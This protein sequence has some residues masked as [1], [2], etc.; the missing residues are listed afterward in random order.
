MTEHTL[1]AACNHNLA[2]NY[3]ARGLL[4]KAETFARRAL[5]VRQ[6]L[7][8]SDH[9]DIAESLRTCAAILR[10]TGRDMEAAPMA[11]RADAIDRRHSID[12]PHELASS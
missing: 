9:P 5:D 12:P 2:E 1:V 10:A 8:L 4:A 3:R 6:R 7:L 11:E